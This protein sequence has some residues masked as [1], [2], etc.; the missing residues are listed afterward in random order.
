MRL[1]VTCSLGSS[2]VLKIVDRTTIKVN[3][4]D[5]YA[6]TTLPFDLHIETDSQPFVGDLNGDYLDDIMYTEAGANSQ[7]LVALQLPS[8]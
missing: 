6:F 5:E 2:T 3:L 8:A 7:I 4:V 1:F